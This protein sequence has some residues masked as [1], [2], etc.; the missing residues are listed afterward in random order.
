M[1]DGVLLEQ[2]IL[3]NQ[4]R[5]AGIL[6]FVLG[7]IFSLY[8]W[9]AKRNNNYS[10]R[11]FFSYLSHSRGALLKNFF[12]DGPGYLVLPLLLIAASFLE[13]HL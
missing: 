3:L 4:K 12:I 13:Q 10:L 11:F 2:S 6:F 5:L 7:F 9:Q 8:L 1:L